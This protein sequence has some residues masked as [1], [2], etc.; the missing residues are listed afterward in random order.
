M[1]ISQAAYLALLTF[2]AIGAICWVS[3]GISWV[4]KWLAQAPVLPRP[5]PDARDSMAEHY[6]I[7]AKKGK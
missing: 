1:S 7:I 2:G 5:Q 3:A 4:I 6:R